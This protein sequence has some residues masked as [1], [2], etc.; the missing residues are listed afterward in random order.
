MIVA[1]ARKVVTRSGE[2]CDTHRDTAPGDVNACPY[3]DRLKARINHL[4]QLA[5]AGQYNPNPVLSVGPPCGPAEPTNVSYFAATT[6]AGR[7]VSLVATCGTPA[8][9]AAGAW[10]SPVFVRDAGSA[11]VVDDILRDLAHSGHFVSIYAG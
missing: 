11:T 6:S 9:D 7:T 2:L 1:V 8:A 5:W 10:Q 3:S 4:Y